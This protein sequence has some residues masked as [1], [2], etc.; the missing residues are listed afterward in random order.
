L[1]LKYQSELGISIIGA[2]EMV[3]CPVLG[4]FVSDTEAAEHGWQTTAISGTKLRQLMVQNGAYKNSEGEGLHHLT[5]LTHKL[6]LLI[7]YFCFLSAETIPSW[8]SFP[9]VLDTLR[10]AL[11]MYRSPSKRGFAILFTGLS[12]SGK[13]TLGQYIN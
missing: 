8:F 5:E 2:N 9:E 13:S 6:T 10:S 3:Y 11:P 12:G 7:H 1:A 4:N